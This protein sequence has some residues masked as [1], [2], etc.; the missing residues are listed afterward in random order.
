MF[1]VF[2]ILSMCEISSLAEALCNAQKG[3]LLKGFTFAGANAYKVDKIISVIDLFK[4]L[5]EEYD[6][7]SLKEIR[8]IRELQGIA[9]S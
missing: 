7:A 6:N 1:A 9:V 3:E 4:M 2:L 8:V 5:Q